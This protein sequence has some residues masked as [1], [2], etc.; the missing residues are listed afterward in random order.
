M[1]KL[2]FYK[3]LGGLGFKKVSFYNV[4]GASK[5]CW[6]END[7]ASIAKHKAFLEKFEKYSA[8]VPVTIG[9]PQERLTPSQN[10]NRGGRAGPRRERQEEGQCKGHSRG[11][12]RRGR[13]FPPSLSEQSSV[14]VGLGW[15]HWCLFLVSLVTVCGVNGWA[16]FNNYNL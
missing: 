3:V 13:N 4:L 15:N 6:L 7:R 14:F 5:M 2:S 10:P 9:T 11:T 8:V 1:K 16:L 12:P